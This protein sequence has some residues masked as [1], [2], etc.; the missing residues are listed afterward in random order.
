MAELESK[1]YHSYHITNIHAKGGD[2]GGTCGGGGGGYGTC[3]GGGGGGG[4]VE[5][6]VF[7][8]EEKSPLFK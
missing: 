6:E 7:A 1:T 2:G 5:V 8:F 3:G 4:D